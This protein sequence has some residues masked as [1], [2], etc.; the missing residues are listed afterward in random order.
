MCAHI[1]ALFSHIQR[2][3][4]NEAV[5][6]NS[7]YH[8][9]RVKKAIAR[10]QEIT[11]KGEDDFWQEMEITK[12]KSTALPENQ[13][14]ALASAH[15]QV[16]I[17]WFKIPNIELMEMLLSENEYAYP[18]LKAYFIRKGTQDETLSLHIGEGSTDKIQEDNQ[19]N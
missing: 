16:G 12:A 18:L 6:T 7:I 3:A 4:M 2:S 17:D 11:G 1:Q 9:K 14:V 8:V 15:L 19:G 5:N 13:P 10:Y